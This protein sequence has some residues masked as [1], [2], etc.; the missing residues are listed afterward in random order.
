MKIIQ[1][2]I[3]IL[4]MIMSFNVYA[5][6]EVITAKNELEVCLKDSDTIAKSYADLKKQEVINTLEKSSLVKGGASGAGCVILSAAVG[7]S[8]LGGLAALCAGVATV[9]GGVSYMNNSN[10]TLSK[11][12]DAFNEAFKLKSEEL[13]KNCFSVLMAKIQSK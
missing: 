6:N 9:V 5:E 10:E 2:S 12:D 1:S 8:D 13:R 11:A 4:L 7:F 3:I